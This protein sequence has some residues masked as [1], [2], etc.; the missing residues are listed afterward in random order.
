[1]DVIRFLIDIL[2]FHIQGLSCVCTSAATLVVI[3][4][5]VVAFFVLLRYVPKLDLRIL[6]R[7]CGHQEQFLILKL[8]V[9]NK[10]LIR[11]SD[12]PV[13]LQVLERPVSEDCILSEWVPFEEYSVRAAE[14]PLEWRDSV[15]VLKDTTAIDPG[16][17]VSVERLYHIP[18]AAVLHIG[19][20]AKVKLPWLARLANCFRYQ[21]HQRTT[22]CYAVSPAA[23]P[24]QRVNRETPIQR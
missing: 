6:P 2:L 14:Q 23:K 16:V 21:T 3:L 13:H 15:E 12:V 8:E 19:L 17:V 9:E 22:T 24:A 7:W 10:S 11:L 1:M 5:G 18:R 20:Q 4:G